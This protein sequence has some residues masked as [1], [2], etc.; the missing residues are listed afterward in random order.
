MPQKPSS[1]PFLTKGTVIYFLLLTLPIAAGFFLP[2]IAI[3][4]LDLGGKS[5]AE[6]EKLAIEQ[7]QRQ[8]WAQRRKTRP[9]GP[10]FAT[11]MEGKR[12]YDAYCM[13]CHQAEGMGKVGFAPFI[14]N[15][16]FLGLASD[17]FLR[18]TI[19]AGRPGTAM[20]SWAHLGRDR[21]ESIIAYLRTAQEGHGTRLAAADPNKRHPGSAQEGEGLYAVYCAACHG[22]GATGYAE[23]GSGPAIGNPT[24][25]AIAS[26][27]YIF[28]TVRHGRIGTPMRS[29][30]GA[31]GLANL[32]SHEVRSIIAYL[33]SERTPVETPEAGGDPS[34][35]KG[36]MHYDAN[37]AACHQPD[38]VGRPGIAPSIRNRDFLAIASDEFIRQTV[39]KGRFGTAMLPRPDLSDQVLNDVIAYLRS[40]G[41]DRAPKVDTDPSADLAS[42]GESAAGRAKFA[43][44]CAAC[45][46]PEGK[47]YAAGGSGPG[48]GLA[49]FLS[50]ASDDYIF[51]TLKH[52]RAGTA[53]RPFL[54]ARGLANLSDQD[55]FDII[56]YLRSL[57]PKSKLATLR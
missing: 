17:D 38:G 10:S 48:I 37:C 52:G 30:I 54:G 26:D 27:D 45:H 46:G 43:V 18:R 12:L 1:A 21:V 51:Q 24:F 49:G 55:A 36:K 35:K 4:L 41:D 47:G 33:R 28:Q 53:M 13:A 56:A 25:L 7:Q 32:S 22:A 40:I 31:G 39:R 44:Y 11:I 20:A 9:E 2:V 5:K 57:S 29:F 6:Q 8:Y 34:P 19:I 50:V 16:D 23:G 42:L 3:S 14:R 15:R